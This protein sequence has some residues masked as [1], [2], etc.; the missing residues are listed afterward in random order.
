PEPDDLSRVPRRDRGVLS[1]RP[2]AP[3]RDRGAAEHPGDRPARRRK[4]RAAPQRGT[5]LDRD[6]AFGSAMT[7][8]DCGYDNID[9]LDACEHCGQDLRSVD[10]PSPR[11]GLQRRIMETPLRELSPAK[12][13]VATARDPVARVVRQ[14]REQRQGSVLVM[15]GNELVGIFTE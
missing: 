3:G 7:C 11:E 5:H 2:T 12:A 14:M 8:P 6:L 10:I 4:C 15:E 13:L 1:R 9:G